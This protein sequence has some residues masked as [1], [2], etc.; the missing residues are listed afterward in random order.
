MIRLK[1]QILLCTKLHCTPVIGDLTNRAT[2]DDALKGV[3]IVIHAA[4]YLGGDR[5]FAEAS[6]VQGV[7]HLV[8]AALAAGVERFVHISTVSVADSNIRGYDGSIGG[9]GA[10][11]GTG[12]GLGLMALDVAFIDDAGAPDY[13]D[14]WLTEF[15][16][17]F[18]TYPIF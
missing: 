9:T 7:Q 18:R 2:L 17:G 12:P 10:P 4:A 14:D 1:Q 6:N 13:T 8:D 15:I 3:H 16:D 11:L 5:A